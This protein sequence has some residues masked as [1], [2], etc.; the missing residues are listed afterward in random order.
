MSLKFR[1]TVVKPK[2]HLHLLLNFESEIPCVSNEE[3]VSQ[4]LPNSFFQ[5]MSQSF[6]ILIVVKIRKDVTL[7]THLIEPYEYQSQKNI[8]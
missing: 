3:D 7:N 6:Q 5:S 4:C 1:T 8:F 2:L